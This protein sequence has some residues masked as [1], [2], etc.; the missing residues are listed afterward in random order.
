MTVTGTVFA[1]QYALA[2]TGGEGALASGTV[3]GIAAGSIFGV[4]TVVGLSI[5]MWR[6]YRDARRL[7]K[8]KMKLHDD[9]Y[10]NEMGTS[11]VPTFKGVPVKGSA[12]LAMT[13][14][15]LPPAYTPVDPSSKN[16]WRDGRT[17]RV[18]L[19]QECLYE[20]PAGPDMQV[21]R[22]QRLSRGYPRVVYTPGPGSSASSSSERMDK[23]LDPA[24]SHRISFPSSTKQRMS[25]YAASMNF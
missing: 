8:L 18:E 5:M 25:K 4:A 7:T 12:A 3:A 2:D 23:E 21:A 14:C 16:W 10:G 20:L 1:M 13:P 17:P 9:F 19:P 6:H 15:S 11:E 24:A 22:P